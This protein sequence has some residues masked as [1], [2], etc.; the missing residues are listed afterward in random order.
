MSLFSSAKAST[1]PDEKR[2][3]GRVVDASTQEGLFGASVFAE[4]LKRGT[5]TK[6]DG[7]YSLLLPKGAHLIRA[8]FVGYRAKEIRIELSSDMRLDI[9]LEPDAIQAPEI[10]VS[11]D[12]DKDRLLESTQS[13]DVMTKEDLDAHRGQ[14]FGE[15]LKNLA[16]VSLLQTG[17]SIAKPVVRGL[18]G[19]RIAIMNAGLKQEG[20]QWGEEHAPEIDPF[21]ASEVQLLRGAASVEYGADAIGGVIR[22]EPKPLFSSEGLRGEVFVNLFANNRQGAVSGYVE[23]SFSS[24]FG[25]RL[26]GSWR[27]AG[28]SFASN[29]ILA[30]TA[31]SELSGSL[32]L[33]L[34]REWGTATLYCSR[35]AAELGIFR[36]AH[37]GNFSDLARAI[38]RG[39]PPTALQQISFAYAI[40]LPRQEVAHDLVSLRFAFAPFSFGAFS[41]DA[42]FQLNRRKEFDAQRSAVARLGIPSLNLTLATT[43]LD[44]KLRHKPIGDFIGT[45]G[46]STSAQ[47]NDVG[48]SLAYLVPRF[49]AFSVGAFIREEIPMNAA[50]LNAGLRYDARL[51]WA[52]PRVFDQSVQRQ[53]F[54]NERRLFQAI[55]AS[56]GAVYQFS[57]SWSIG[58]NV[59]T[60]WR[61][62]S[63]NELYAD[64][65]HH[66]TG[67]YEVGD[68]NLR[69]EKS[70]GIDATLRRQSAR[71]ELEASAF[72]NRFSGFIFLEPTGLI[73]SLRGFFPAHRYAQS[74]ARLLG[75][76]GTL[77]YAPFEFL[78]LDAT[79]SLIRGRNLDREEPLINVPQDRLRAI[80]HVHLFETE[81]VKDFYLELGATAARRQ[82][83]VPFVARDSIAQPNRLIAGLFPE[84]TEA[85]ALARYD[86]ILRLL[87]LAPPGYVIWEL[88]AGATI[89]LGGTSLKIIVSAQNLF[90]ARYRDYLSRFRLYADDIGRNVI[91]RVQLP[92]GSS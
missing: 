48:R 21:A 28:D 53:I 49:R 15:S 3:Y 22:S 30:N 1:E 19:Q 23:H 50:S 55:T 7:S 41:L 36:G 84:M 47:F 65:V 59:G 40:G 70:Y 75:F 64:G 26:Q 27:K 78:R 18:H 42:G 69:V 80:A 38:E 76:D 89:R 9:A 56:A 29:Y 8:R 4:G 43:S 92:F 20:Q 79:L 63:I 32:M 88:N 74:D 62:P 83:L 57:R 6:L 2:L 81:S 67:Q 60:A 82:T 11:T 68:R 31:F 86:R 58:L 87:T 52:S 73:Q 45:V 85:D 35:F 12:R 37:L 54:I 17:V 90:N 33:G 34:K 61:P 91:A 44:A 66:G 77:R 71:L 16:G 14:T 39:E 51:L 5:T 25:F 72:Y 10:T 46:V 13:L 24:G